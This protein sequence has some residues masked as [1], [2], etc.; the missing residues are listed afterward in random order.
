MKG[1]LLKINELISGGTFQ[2][3][4]KIT[5]FKYKINTI[6]RTK[7]RGQMQTLELPEIVGKNKTFYNTLVLKKDDTNHKN[8]M[9]DGLGVSQTTH[10]PKDIRK[11]VLISCR[12][13]KK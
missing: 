2:S 4:C 8:L 5:K 3:Y 10:I 6:S 7:E 12:H 11:I 1:L 13:V 9:E